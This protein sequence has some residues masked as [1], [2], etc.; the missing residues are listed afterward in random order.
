MSHRHDAPHPTPPAKLLNLGPASTAWLAAVGVVTRDDLERLGS[1]AAFARVR[2]VQPKASH[3]L[4]WALEGALRGCDWRDLTAED[5]AQLRR[6][7]VE[8]EQ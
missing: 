6:E 4:L 5:K 1:V 3:N 7:V 8:L 2:R